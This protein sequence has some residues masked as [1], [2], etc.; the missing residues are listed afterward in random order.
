MSLNTI[1]NQYQV[2]TNDTPR[3]LVKL[4]SHSDG[5]F[6]FSWRK[7]PFFASLSSDIK[8]NS[9][10]EIEEAMRLFIEDTQKKEPYLRVIV[11]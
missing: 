5:T 2:T 4:E 8:S 6:S 10:A 11:E 3:I 9:K 7:S 1:T